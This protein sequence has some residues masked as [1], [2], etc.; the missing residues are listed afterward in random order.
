[1]KIFWF[2]T[3]FF[4]CVCKMFDDKSIMMCIS[5]YGKHSD[6]LLW[7]RVDLHKSAEMQKFWIINI[8]LFSKVKKASEMQRYSLYFLELQ[9]YYKHRDNVRQIKSFEEIQIENKIWINKTISS[10]NHVA[11]YILLS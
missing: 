1:M 6:L 4:F 2:K 10:S 11:F 7:S 5:V 8:E 9:R 3:N